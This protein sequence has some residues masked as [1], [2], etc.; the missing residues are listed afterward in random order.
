[1]RFDAVLRN[2]TDA[3]RLLVPSGRCPGEV[4]T[5]YLRAPLVT[6][7]SKEKEGKEKGKEKKKKKRLSKGF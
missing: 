4:V 1:M 3:V 6:K 5:A 2:G 7:S